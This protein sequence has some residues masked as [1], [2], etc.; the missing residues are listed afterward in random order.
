MYLVSSYTTLEGA[1]PDTILQN[2]QSPGEPGVLEDV[3]F[4]PSHSLL[5]DANLSVIHRSS[6]S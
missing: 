5:A 2:T 1:S 4:K 3:L 6:L